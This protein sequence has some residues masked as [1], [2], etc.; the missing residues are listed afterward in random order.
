MSRPLSIDSLR[1]R[2]AALQAERDTLLT[3]TRSRAEVAILLESLVAQS[4]AAGNA[5]VARELQKASMGAP[6]TPLVNS[7]PVLVA[8]MGHDAVKSALRGPLEAIPLGMPTAERLSRLEVIESELFDLETREESICDSEGI[9][10]RPN[11]RPEI[12]LCC[13][14]TS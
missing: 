9:E 10:R 1:K 3:Q 14:F 4:F 13:P 12:I 6:F 2:I 11:A 8:L 5:T 7:V